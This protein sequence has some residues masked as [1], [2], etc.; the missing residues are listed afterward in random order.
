M[1]PFI[2]KNGRVIDPYNRVD[3]IRDLGISGQRLVDPQ[4]LITDPQ[5]EVIDLGGA[6]VAPGL[7]DIHVHLREPGYEY[8]ETIALGTAAAAAGGFTTVVAMPNTN[9]PMDTV[10]RIADLQARIAATARIRALITGCLTL[11]RAGMA[12]T[13]IAAL[14]QQPGIVALSD[15]GDCVQ[16]Y[17]LMK[18]AAILAKE[19]ELPIVDHCEDHAIRAGGV[20][21]VGEISEWMRIPGMPGET[22][23]NMVARNIKLSRETGS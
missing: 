23:S 14:R 9:P 12:L 2:L 21:R 6:I 4:L 15:D 17:N 8:K 13:D 22:E 19:H 18:Q 10:A 3:E 1:T 5:V 7:I 11:D 16:D 20:M